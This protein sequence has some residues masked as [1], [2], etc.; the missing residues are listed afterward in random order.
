M[1]E[2][3]TRI[4]IFLEDAPI[5]FQPWWL[6]TV[7]PGRWDYAVVYRGNDVAA[8]LPY[9]YKIR[10]KRFLLIEMPPL[11]P[12]L[13]PWLRKSSAK[14]ANQLS[15]QKVLMNEL[16]DKLPSFSLY[17]QN[18]HPLVS[19][20]LPFYWKNFQ[21]TTRY[22]Y[23]FENSMDVDELWNNTL[24]KVRTDV[25]KA[26]NIVEIIEKNDIIEFI[27]LH[28]MTF[29]RQ[30]KILPYRIKYLERLNDYLVEK[31]Q[32]KI[33]FAVDQKDMI[34][35]SVFLVWDNKTVYYLLSGADPMLRN[36]GAT[37]LLVWEA[38]KFASQSGKHFDFEGSVVE[39]IERFVRGFGGK[40][41]PYSEIY[42]NNSYMIFLYRK[43]WQIFHK[44]R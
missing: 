37:S 21:Q 25:R 12:Y 20:W 13:G 5:F 8:V 33:L 29:E 41:T 17:H 43:I 44:T 42:K 35:A 27:H 39:S 2:I 32:C 16:I 30:K 19:N 14:Y 34:H 36:S 38:I 40:Q 24:D 6:E 1:K 22:T 3:D 18:F 7:A 10:L 23:I 11:T 9:T 4:T 15:E 26:E 28:Q 31:N